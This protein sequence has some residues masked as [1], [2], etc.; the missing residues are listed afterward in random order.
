[1][2]ATFYNFS[3]DP[4]GTIMATPIPLLSDT[5]AHA[6][7]CAQC[8]ATLYQRTVYLCGNGV[9][10]PYTAYTPGAANSAIGSFPVGA[11]F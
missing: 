4:A 5:L 11:G 7:T 1:M 10:E 2:A 8:I 6:Q 3:F 9:A